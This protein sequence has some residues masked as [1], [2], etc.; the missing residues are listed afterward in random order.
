[1][2]TL[3]L[4]TTLLFITSNIFSQ[5]VYQKIDSLIKDAHSKNPKISFSVGFVKNDTEFYTSHEKFR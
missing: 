1:M 5:G 3:K 2:K 4:L